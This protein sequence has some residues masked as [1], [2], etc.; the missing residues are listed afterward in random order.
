MSREAPLTRVAAA[1]YEI[2]TDAPEADGTLEWDRTVLVVV[3]IEAG[4]QTGLGYTYAEG[5]IVQLIEGKLGSVISERSA[6]DIAGA[7]GALWRSIRNLGRSGLVATA[8]SA[9]DAALWDL[10]AKLLGTS[11]AALLGC[12]RETVSIY[13]SGGFTTYA[14]KQL[15]NQLSGWTERDGCRWVKMKIGSD[16][17]CDPERVA[18]ARDAIG[19]AGLFVDA[20][21]AFAAKQAL[22]LA[23]RIAEH[24]VRW[25]EEPVTSDDVVGLALVRDCAPAGM[26][27]AAGEYGYNLDDFRRLLELPS[28]DVLQADVT[29]CGGITGFM[30]VAALCEARHIELSGHCAPALHLHAACAAPRLRHLEWFHDHVRIERMLFDGAPEPRDGEIAPDFSR[31]GFGLVFKKR[32][33]ERFRIG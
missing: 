20:N 26:D 2:P 23:E 24:D 5:S 33:A 1:A 10:K 18:V 19:D 11:V 17:A 6:F 12:C 25:F 7:N 15:R 3:E 14:D 21:G 29:R 16:P 22:A 9:V 13:G 28:I 8:I 4:G 27:I 30:Q 31:P 32:D